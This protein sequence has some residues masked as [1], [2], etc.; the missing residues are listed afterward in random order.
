MI[1]HMSTANVAR[2]MDRLRQAVGDSKLSYYG[3]SYGSMLGQTYAN[4]FPDHFRA[5]VIDGVL[6]PI[7][8]TTGRR[9]RAGP[10][11]LDAAAQ[12]PGR[13]RHPRGVLP[14]LRR[15]R[16]PRVRW[17][18]VPA[19]RL[20]T[21]PSPRRCKAA[22]IMITDPSTGRVLR[23]QLLVPHRRHP[24]RD[25]RLV[26]VARPRELPR[27]P[28]GGGQPGR[29]WARRWPTSAGRAPWRGRRVSCRAPRRAT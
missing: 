8:W 12:R 20:G 23:V 27:V 2:D 25:V 7:A 11:V 9:R 24:Q 28:R 10:A 29:R 21:P 6:D 22:P 5:L 4:M 17:P 16:T 13:D 14:A 1:D 18:A 26:L 19:R 15:G 3:V